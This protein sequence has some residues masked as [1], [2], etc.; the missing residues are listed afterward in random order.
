[1][2]MDFFLTCFPLQLEPARQ[3]GPRQ[4]LSNERQNFFILVDY[5]FLTF[6]A[7]FYVPIIFS[8]LNSNCS[9]SLDLRNLQ[10]QVKKAFCYHKF[11]CPSTV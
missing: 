8:N 5:D 11:S 2:E 1:M 10:E 4:F 9:N 6:P 7:C 3:N